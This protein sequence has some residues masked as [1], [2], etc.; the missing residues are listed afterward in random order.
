MTTGELWKS[1]FVFGIAVCSVFLFS[2]FPSTARG[3][4]KEG[5]AVYD[6]PP[7]PSQTHMD[8]LKKAGWSP[9]KIGRF[10][11]VYKRYHRAYA[12]VRLPEPVPGEH[13]FLLAE[14]ANVVTRNEVNPYL[15]AAIHPHEV[16][17]GVNIGGC[18]FYGE[19][20]PPP[21]PVKEPSN[22]EKER[23]RK[24]EREKEAFGVI[25]ADIKKNPRWRTLEKEH[26]SVACLGG[27]VGYFQIKP[28][29]WLHYR[30]DV[31]VALG[32]KTASPYEPIPALFAA[33]LI[34]RDKMRHLGLAQRTVTM[35]NSLYFAKVAAAYNRGAVGVTSNNGCITKYGEEVYNTA[36][37]LKKAV[38]KKAVKPAAIRPRDS[39]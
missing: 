33:H 11:K 28:T 21:T 23:Q 13:L 4:R 9:E 14:W 37:R 35:E 1:V 29:V 25:I 34:V 18:S 27:D 16:Y 22:E 38:E 39:Y 36:M 26:P 20:P 5:A 7:V 24:F 6:L 17:K 19:A 15:V 31:L 2:L 30:D 12:F 8:A 10:L 3:E 32:L